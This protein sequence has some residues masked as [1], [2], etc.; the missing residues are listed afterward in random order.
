[1]DALVYGELVAWDPIKKQRAWQVRH[2]KPSNGGI[3]STA[4]DL[5]FQGTWD[6]TFAAYDAEMAPPSGNTNQTAPFLPARSVMNWMANSISPWLRA[7][8]AR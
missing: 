4:G 2:D 8:A 3:L 1:M 6:G 5:V 7:V